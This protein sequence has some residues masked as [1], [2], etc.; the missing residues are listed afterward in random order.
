M[1]YGWEKI[2]IGLAEK[3]CRKTTTLKLKMEKVG[4]RRLWIV[5]A[6]WVVALLNIGLSY[7][8]LKCNEAWHVNF[9]H[10]ALLFE[11]YEAA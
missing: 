9:T 7:Q 1:S 11:K 6:V 4:G 3:I 8:V 10:F 5:L 2:N